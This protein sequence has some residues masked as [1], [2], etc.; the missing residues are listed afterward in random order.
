MTL[1]EFRTLDINKQANAVWSGTF[2]DSV[3][4]AKYHGYLYNVHNFYVKV[5]YSNEL[6]EIIRIRAFRST[7]LIN[8]FL[9]SICIDHFQL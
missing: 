6:N 9:D 3:A 7:S 8:P 4:K 2:L 1:K 5:Y